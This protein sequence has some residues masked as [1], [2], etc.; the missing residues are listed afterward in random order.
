MSVCVKS[1]ASKV[2][3]SSGC[4]PPPEIMPI[5]ERPSQFAPSHTHVAAAAAVAAPARQDET[6]PTVTRHAEQGARLYPTLGIHGLQFLH[7]QLTS[8]HRQQRHA[9]VKAERLFQRQRQHQS[10]QD[11]LTRHE[12]KRFYA[13][14]SPLRIARGYATPWS[15]PDL[16]SAAAAMWV[17]GSRTN[18]VR[19]FARFLLE[20]VTHGKERFGTHSQMPP[21]RL[22]IPRQADL[23]T[24]P[25][26]E[27]RN[28]CTGTSLG[29]PWW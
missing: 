27:Q 19:H 1:G 2:W 14:A 24:T 9:V 12:D 5:H 4:S 20:H 7:M 26:D 18:P 21:R 15:H 3:K 22:Q 29:L 28:A 6:K 25:P 13:S 17:V 8:S 23:G 11:R 10:L 16:R